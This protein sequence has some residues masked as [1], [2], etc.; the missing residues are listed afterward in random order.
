M[1]ENQALNNYFVLSYDICFEYNLN[2]ADHV[3]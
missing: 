2:I 3:Y 1:R